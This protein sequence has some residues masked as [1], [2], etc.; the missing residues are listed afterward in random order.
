M[1]SAYEYLENFQLKYIKPNSTFP[2]L[3]RRKTLLKNG[4]LEMDM[5]NDSSIYLRSLMS[6]GRVYLL[7]DRVHKSKVTKKLKLN[8][9]LENMN[10]KK[11]VYEFLKEYVKEIN[12][13]EWYEKQ[14]SFTIYYYLTNSKCSKM[15]MKKL[16]EW[17]KQNTGKNKFKILFKIL[18]IQIKKKIG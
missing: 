16:K 8:F 14:I 18:K 13:E 17:C 2:V 5:I 3:F 15:D 4:I 7:E 10:E 1:I 6:N 11:K 9:I 12:A